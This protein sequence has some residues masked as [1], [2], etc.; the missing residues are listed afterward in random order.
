VTMN[1][2]FQVSI[3]DIKAGRT[4]EA[5]KTQPLTSASTPKKQTTTGKTK[6]R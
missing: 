3:A 4:A 2:E 6:R 1:E 5:G